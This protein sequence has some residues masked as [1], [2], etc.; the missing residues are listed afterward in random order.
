ML[1][2]LLEVS[3]LSLNLLGLAAFTSSCGPVSY[4]CTG[5]FQKVWRKESSHCSVAGSVCVKHVHLDVRV[6]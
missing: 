3:L 1:P 2:V 4:C 5:G 6:S